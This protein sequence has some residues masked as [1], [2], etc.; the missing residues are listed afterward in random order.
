MI[1]IQLYTL[2]CRVSILSENIVGHFLLAHW[3]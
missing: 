2:N 3:V 1:T